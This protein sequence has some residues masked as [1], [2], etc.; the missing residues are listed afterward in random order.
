MKEYQIIALKMWDDIDGDHIWYTGQRR[1]VYFLFRGFWQDIKP[2]WHRTYEEVEK[3][4]K[5][6]KSL[7][8]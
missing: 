4:I 6:S 1:N 3:Q 2:M 5:E 8:A 7:D